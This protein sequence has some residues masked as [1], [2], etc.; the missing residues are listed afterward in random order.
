MATWQLYMATCVLFI[1]HLANDAQ[2]LKISALFLWSN[3]LFAGVAISGSQV[4]VIV[5]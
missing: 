2:F 5:L 1:T 4:I 3:L